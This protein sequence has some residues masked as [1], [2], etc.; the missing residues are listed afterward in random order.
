MQ[1]VSIKLSSLSIQEETMRRDTVIFDLDNTLVNRKKAY[2]K[3]SH[4]FID[5]FVAC[6]DSST[7]YDIVE[8][9]RIADNNG[10][11][12]KQELY[13]ELFDRLEKQNSAT[14]AD[15]MIQFWF[16]DFYKYTELMDNALSVLQYLQSNNY[17]IALIT[18]GSSR[19]Q[20]S[21]IDSVQLRP[22][23]DEI[24]VSDDV[25]CKKPHRSIFDLTLARLEATPDQCWYIGDHPINDIKGANEVGIHTIWLQG[26]MEQYKNSGVASYTI[27]DLNEIIP[28]INKYNRGDSVEN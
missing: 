14:T 26:F 13:E 16:S 9:M 15:D 21:K 11:R 23:F 3:F 8:Q 5:R 7:R 10:Y 4:A 20:H 2:E 17:K 6:T 19:S 1:A 22:F 25:G 28:I 18:N 12:K 27:N 24:I